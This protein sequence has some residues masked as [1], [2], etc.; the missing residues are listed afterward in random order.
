MYTSDSIT[1]K[2]LAALFFT[3]YGRS[4]ASF[5]RAE[6]GDVIRN[7]LLAE[8]VADGVA[9]QYLQTPQERVETRTHPL[10]KGTISVSS[11]KSRFISTQ[12]G[13]FR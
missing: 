8:H 11:L 5:Q 13:K 1:R 2:D 3:L 7:V 4:Q 6:G 9:G 10:P 12:G